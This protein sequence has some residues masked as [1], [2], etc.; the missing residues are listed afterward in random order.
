MQS[1]ALS[2]S[3]KLVG[4]TPTSL[5]SLSLHCLTLPRQQPNAPPLAISLIPAFTLP[6]PFSHTLSQVTTP[7]HSCNRTLSVS[8]DHRLTISPSSHSLSSLS[9]ER[10]EAKTQESKGELE[11]QELRRQNPISQD[12]AGG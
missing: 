10:I 4:P 12:E 8:L 2:F 1:R 5:F 11:T 6:F 9:E 3:P 7:T